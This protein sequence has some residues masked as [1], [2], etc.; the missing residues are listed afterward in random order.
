MES[1][2]KGKCPVMHG[3]NTAIDKT[4]MD[5][6]PNALNLDILHQHDS[7][8]NPLG[9]D[10]NYREAL[11]KLDVEALKKDLHNL[12][13]DSQDW[14]PADW[15]HYGGLMIRMAWHAAGSYRIADG[16]GGAG[17]GNQRFAPLNS[18]PDNV[19]LDKARRLLWPIKKKYGNKLS[20]ADLIILAGT[21][22][23]ESMGLKTFGFAFGREDIWGPEKD[24]YWGAEKEWLAPSDERYENVDKPSTMENPLAAVQMGLIYV[25]PEGVNGKP[26]PLKTAAQ[27]RETFK[28]MAMN[29]EETVALTAGGHTV[30][31]TH[32][33]GDASILGLDP[34]SAPVEEQGLGWANPTRTGIGRDTVTSGLEGAWTTHPTKW[35]DG[36]F[37]MLFNHDW[38]LRKSPAGAWQWEPISIKEEDM[39]VDVEDMTTRHNPIMT[40]ADMAMKV[41]P[42]YK[43]ISLKYKNDFNAFSEAFASAW[44]KLTHRDMGPKERYFGPDA[45]KE[46]LIWQDPVPQGKKDYNVNAV[47]EKIANS[48]LS[49]SEMV[50]TAWDSARTFRGSD[51]RGGANGARIRLAPQ[52]DW[53]GNEP[54]RLSKVLSILEPIAK[55][56]GISIADTIVLAGNIGIEKAIKNAGMNI[57][58]PFAPGRGDAT[59]DMTDEE[60]FE[61]LEPVADGYRNWL[62]KDYVVSPEELMLDRTQ[63]M[64]LTASE[65]TV[66]VGGMRVLETNFGNTKHGAFTNNVGSLT[67]DFFVNLTDMSY[68][69]KPVGNG[70]YEICN[71]KSGDVKWTASRIDL[72]FGSNSIL[73]SYAEVYAQDD[74][75]EKFVKDFVNAWTKVMNAD[76]FDLN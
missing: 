29:D 70:V 71:R 22:A 7:K 20:W 54:K 42:I 6:W 31:K 33:N 15:G 64:G 18:W 69:W 32:G 59:D 72:V 1:P 63:L 19:S 68:K 55:E 61:Y 3:A 43:E 35:D 5:W 11:K 2:T 4:V 17:T 46:D 41:D 48:R 66:L 16:R 58:V 57:L 47:K 12:M 39:P 74:N 28:R 38:E 76:R 9:K 23:Y 40:D 45:P 60:S 37:E 34:E 8:T 53:E 65:M 13:K 52:K 75:K 51:F 44:F 25:N 24:T 36:F 73:R 14:W 10:F 27:V 49:I 21:I 62:K 50:S 56:F 26:D 30:G 67:N